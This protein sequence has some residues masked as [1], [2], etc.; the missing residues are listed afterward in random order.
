M[1]QYINTKEMRKKCETDFMNSVD[2]AENLSRNLDLPFRESYHLIAKAVKISEPNWDGTY[3]T[4]EVIR[5]TAEQ[6]IHNGSE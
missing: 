4:R 1:R 6:Y 2:F 5:E 3:D